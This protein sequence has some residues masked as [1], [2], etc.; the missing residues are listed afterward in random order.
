ME[1]AIEMRTEGKFVSMVWN[2][3]KPIGVLVTYSIVGGENN[4][5]ISGDTGAAKQSDA[6]M[7]RIDQEIQWHAVA[8]PEG[9][10]ICSR[11]GRDALMAERV[12]TGINDLQLACILCIPWSVGGTK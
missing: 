11:C 5:V 3:G 10:E 4:A 7:D 6:T 1:R 2:D 12:L 9:V 8:N